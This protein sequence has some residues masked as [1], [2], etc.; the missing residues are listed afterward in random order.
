MS[1]YVEHNKLKIDQDSLGI[2]LKK[3]VKRT[4][5]KVIRIKV[6]KGEEPILTASKF[7]GCPY[8]PNNLDYPVNS[9]GEKL[10]LLAQINMKDISNELFPKQ[11]LLQFFISTDDL[12]G[13]DDENGYKVVYHSL[14]DDS[15]TKDTVKAMGIRS[16]AD[17]NDEEE[18]MPFYDCF[19][20]TFEEDCEYVSIDSD[21]FEE[22]FFKALKS[23]FGIDVNDYE[24]H[25]YSKMYSFIENKDYNYI[26]KVAKD[27]S[28]HK[29]LGN[30]YFTQDD[31]RE[32]DDEH[33][34][35]LF[36]MDSEMGNEDVEIMW[37]DSGVG[38]FFISE[39]DLKNLNFENVLYT[40]DCC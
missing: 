37:G 36:Q 19:P 9:E 26:A 15:I 40:W 25:G 6:H 14:I 39:E 30:P 10:V 35:L 11:G 34:I 24:I 7:G 12:N 38:N 23:E 31:P 27:N 29:I 32:E 2:I 4:D 22:D 21:E 5:K 8:W 28:G 16:A 3:V 13:L 20:I 33:N 17:L 1:V 18:Y